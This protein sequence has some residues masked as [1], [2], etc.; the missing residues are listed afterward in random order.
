VNEQSMRAVAVAA[1]AGRGTSDERALDDHEDDHRKTHHRGERGV[2][3]GSVRSAGAWPLQQPAGDRGGRHVPQPAR[4]VA[5]GVDPDGADDRDCGDG[6]QR[7]RQGDLHA[8]AQDVSAVDT[9]CLE[10]LLRYAAHE[11]RVHE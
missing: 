4:R 11:D 10:D 9:T 7:Q 8:G 3:G 6:R 2:L 5:V 1:H